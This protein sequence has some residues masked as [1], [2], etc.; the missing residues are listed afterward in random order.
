MSHISTQS[1][2]N[3]TF[4]NRQLITAKLLTWRFWPSSNLA[5]STSSRRLPTPFFQDLSAPVKWGG[6]S[7]SWKPCV[8]F[9]RLLFFFPFFNSHTWLQQQAWMSGWW[10]SAEDDLCASHFPRA[11]SPS[12]SDPPRVRCRWLT[13]KKSEE[14][15]DT[16]SAWRI[17][18]F[19]EPLRRRHCHLHQHHLHLTWILQ[20]QG[21]FEVKK[22]SA[23][24]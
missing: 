1:T 4:A 14:M 3:K 24:P 9:Q 2:W 23:E 16:A 7:L 6:G 22:G 10:L 20:E 15:C 18:R 12:R 8:V 11:K 5:A 19:I 21:L 13:Y 17:V